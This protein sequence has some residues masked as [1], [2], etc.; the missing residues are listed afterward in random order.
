MKCYCLNNFLSSLQEKDIDLPIPHKNQVLLK[1]KASG[2]CHSDIHLCNG[3]YDMGMGKRFE[4]KDRGI[5]LPLVLGHEIVGN[6]IAKGEEVQE[7]T[8]GDN[9]IVYPWIGCGICESC[10]ASNENYCLNPQYLGINKPGGFAEYVLVPDQKYLV[11]IK[12]MDPAI[13]AQYACAGLTTYSAINKIEKNIY[14]NKPVVIFGAGGLGLMTISILKALGAY[15]SVVITNDLNKKN[16]ALEA[17]ALA[18]FDYNDKN[19][20]K[21]LLNYNFN[22]K[23]YAVIDLVGNTI[24]TKASFDILEKSA[25]LIIVGMFGGL[26]NWPLAFIPMKALKIIGSYVGNLSEF[27]ELMKLV[28]DQKL[29]PVQITKYSFDKVNEALSDL[30]AG[31]IVGRAVITNDNI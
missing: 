18:V 25:S 15:G 30:R 1:V 13:V 16:A 29:E 10:K 9:Y 3:Y 22:N 5:E 12:N 19:L 24:T 6:V 20:V 7:I 17:G 8:I 21:E 11:N 2:I 31:R 27:N 23:Y 14:K 26:S 28:V 4:L